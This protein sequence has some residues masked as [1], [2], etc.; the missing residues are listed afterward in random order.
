MSSKLDMYILPIKAKEVLTRLEYRRL[1]PEELSFWFLCDCFALLND[2]RLS[3]SLLKEYGLPG[4]KD[5]SK[6]DELWIKVKHLFEGPNK[7]GFYTSAEV[8]WAL[9]KTRSRQVASKKGNKARWSREITPEQRKVDEIED[10]KDLLGVLKE[11][12][13]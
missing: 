1:A 13:S 3:L 7:E 10:L 5:L 11:D 6:Y 12:G 9:N 4:F 8:T 2:N